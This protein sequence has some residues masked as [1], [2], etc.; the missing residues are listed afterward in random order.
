MVGVMSTLAVLA[1]GSLG[2]SPIVPVRFVFWVSVPIIG[3]L[4]WG[5]T[6]VRMVI[7]V[8]S[9]I[10]PVFLPISVVLVSIVDTFLR[11]VAIAVPWFDGLGLIFRLLAL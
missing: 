9:L 7:L 4:E 11:F 8:M 6:I 3:I 10:W 2:I 1:I 5:V